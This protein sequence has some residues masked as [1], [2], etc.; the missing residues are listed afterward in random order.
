MDGTFNTISELQKRIFGSMNSNELESEVFAAKN[1][2]RLKLKMHHINS[3]INKLS[4]TT[5]D[6][7]VK[8]F[9]V[10]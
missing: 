5:W 8:R 3:I 2:T 10:Y 9:K 1:E 6:V 7:V 4:G